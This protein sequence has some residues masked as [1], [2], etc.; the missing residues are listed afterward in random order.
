M[1]ADQ[2]DSKGVRNQELE[3][4]PCK[5]T[6]NGT[7]LLHLLGGMGFI[8]SIDAI[9]VNPQISEPKLL[10]HSNG[11]PDGV[12]K[13]TSRIDGQP[14]CMEGASPQALTRI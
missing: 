5:P 7:H 14:T 12:G 10:R 2:E 1:M 3:E 6:D 8:L 4:D 11:V 9:A 13:L